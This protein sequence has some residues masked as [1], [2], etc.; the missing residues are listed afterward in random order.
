[1][2]SA[3]L[4]KLIDD[5]RTSVREICEL[6]GRGESTVYRWLAGESQPTYR[7]IELLVRQ[8]KDPMARE[9]LVCLMLMGLPV[10]VEWLE[11][12]ERDQ[13][14]RSTDDKN[15]VFLLTLDAMKQVTTLLDLERKLITGGAM[16][17]SDVLEMVNLINDTVRHLTATKAVLVAQNP[18][19]RRARPLPPVNVQEVDPQAESTN[20]PDN[21]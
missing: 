2:L 4:Q 16:R 9:Q 5:H 21:C 18:A 1:M 11:G 8:V 3:L 17:E 6:T 19:R 14:K 12:A 20:R 10:V 7:D 13:I 15:T